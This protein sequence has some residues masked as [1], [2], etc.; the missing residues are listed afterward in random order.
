MLMPARVVATLTEAQTRSVAAS[1]S[2]IEAMSRRSPSP[3]PL[4][5]SAEKPPMKST[6]TSR[7]RAV[8]RR[9]ERRDVLGVARRGELRDRRDRDAL[10]DDRDAVLALDRVGDRHEALGGAR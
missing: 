8:E 9:G 1:A 5:T 2:G 3:M 6:P 4:C 7:G 10:V